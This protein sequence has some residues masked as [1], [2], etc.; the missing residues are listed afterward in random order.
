MEQFTVVDVCDAVQKTMAT[1][2]KVQSAQNTIVT[3]SK[4][5]EQKSNYFNVLRT[6]LRYVINLFTPCTQKEL[7]YRDI[8]K[9][10]TDPDALLKRM[11][12]PAQHQTNIGAPVPICTW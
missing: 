6:I 9:Y 10:F 12:A 2:K 1:T 4:A 3:T 7:D 11:M 8:T 5:V